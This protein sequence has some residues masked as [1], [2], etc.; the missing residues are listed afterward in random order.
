[1]CTDFEVVFQGRCKN[2]GAAFFLLSLGMQSYQSLSP[3]ELLPFLQRDALFQ[4]QQEIHVETY[5]SQFKK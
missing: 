5:C 4:E 1:M 3:W 2:C